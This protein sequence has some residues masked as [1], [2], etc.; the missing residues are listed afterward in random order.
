MK[1][2]LSQRGSGV[3]VVIIVLLALTVV[4]LIGWIVFGSSDRDDTV[5]TS[6]E[7]QSRMANNTADDTFAI[8]EWN[9]KG[10]S[11]SGVSLKY[12]IRGAEASFVSSDTEKIGCGYGTAGTI[13]RYG[14][15]DQVLNPAT[16]E[17][18]G[19]AKTYYASA[20]SVSS[21]VG[22]YY[23]QYVAP[24]ATCSDQNITGQEAATKAADQLATSLAAE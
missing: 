20:A 12:T 9:V 11:S 17:S 3:T 19:V 21:H 8:A 7:Q 18:M 1:T 2:T 22:T 6:T 15:N 13:V 24:Q 5:A 10:R 14:E 4:G 16:G 23:Y